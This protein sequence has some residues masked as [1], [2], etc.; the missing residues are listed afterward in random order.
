MYHKSRRRIQTLLPNTTFI[1][2]TKDTPTYTAGQIIQYVGC[3]YAAQHNTTT[4]QHLAYERF[5]ATMDPRA[6]YVDGEKIE[7]LWAAAANLRDRD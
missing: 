7:H 4:K 5:L 6:V 1:M 3:R 2:S